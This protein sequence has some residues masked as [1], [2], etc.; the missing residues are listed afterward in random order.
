MDTDKNLALLFGA[1]AE[2][3]DKRFKRLTVIINKAGKIAKIDKEVEPSS[4][5]ADLVDFF[6][7]LETPKNN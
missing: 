1:A 6:K 5:G 3:S 7:G 2:K 4:H